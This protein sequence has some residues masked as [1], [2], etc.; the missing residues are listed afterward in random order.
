MTLRRITAIVLGTAAVA[1]GAGEWSNGARERLKNFHRP[2]WFVVDG[3][4]VQTQ[5]DLTPAELFTFHDTNGR[6]ALHTRPSPR[7]E[8][9]LKN[10]RTSLVRLSGS[11][12][13]WKLSCPGR[14]WDDTRA[15]GTQHLLLTA[16]VDPQF[17]DDQWRLN[18][19]E[20]TPYLQ[21]VGATV[22]EDGEPTSCV[23]VLGRDFIEA[24][25]GPPGGPPRVLIRA[26]TA[27]QL[28]LDRPTDVRRYV[29]P[30]LKLINGGEN[31][32]APAAA[33]VYR[34]FPDL[35]T[36]AGAA[37][38][39]A[40]L[41]PK[42]NARDPAERRAASEALK[43]L[44]RRAVQAALRVDGSTLPPEAA[45][46]LATFVAEASRDARPPDGLRADASFLLDC[47]TDSDPNV[48]VAAGKLVGK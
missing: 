13:A 43:S 20:I 25:V 36:D 29:V 30:V 12:Y 47:L 39:V 28:L 40:G 17:A 41:L 46:R 8:P 24:A 23:V 48:R 2:G 15:H 45:E 32:L 4:F 1:F 31:P 21:A 11:G 6:F 27:R 3:R 10:Y 19:V 33:D 42:L 44:G 26:P 37:R 22:R 16:A 18:R 7:V 5:A 9:L 35:P 34:A 38:T 14:V